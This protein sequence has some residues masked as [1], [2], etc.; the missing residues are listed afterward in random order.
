MSIQIVSHCYAAK[1]KQYAVDLRYQLSSLVLYPPKVQVGI[2]ICYTYTD[3][4]TIAV[5]REFQNN[6]RK[7]DLTTCGMSG[8]ELFR[9]SIG[10]NRVALTSQEALIWFCDVDYV[11]MSGCLDQLWERWQALPEPKPSIVFPKKIKFHETHALGDALVEQCDG[12][13]GT[14]EIDPTQFVDKTYQRAIGGVQITNGEYARKYGYLNHS[15]K[16]QR[17][18]IS[19]RAFHTIEDSVFRHHASLHGEIKGIDL[20]G[21]YRIRHYLNAYQRR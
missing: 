13:S 16:Y 6:H 20:D 15:E 2:T 9:R 17:T 8:P 12:K 7:L 14:L 19:G 21:V 11:F 5:L 3:V 4:R 10:R 18:V 1:L